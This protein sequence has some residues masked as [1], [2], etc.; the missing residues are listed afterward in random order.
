MKDK[1]IERAV[2]DI[3]GEYDCVLKSAARRS[4]IVPESRLP[5]SGLHYWLPMIRIKKIN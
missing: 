5:P 1:D 3:I 2:F 4:F